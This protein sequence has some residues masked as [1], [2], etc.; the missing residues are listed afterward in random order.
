MKLTTDNLGAQLMALAKKGYDIRPVFDTLGGGMDMVT[1]ITDDDGDAY[2]PECGCK[3]PKLD[4]PATACEKLAM[5]LAATRQHYGLPPVS[6]GRD[7]NRGVAAAYGP[8]SNF[9]G[10]LL[11]SDQGVVSDTAAAGTVVDVAFSGSMLSRLY[12]CQ[13]L[14][15]W[16][17]VSPQS[18]NGGQLVVQSMDVE[19]SLTINDDSVGQF[20]RVVL[21]QIS[22]Q[23][24]GDR[25]AIDLR[26]MNV[27]VPAG[28]TVSFQVR[29]IDT[30]TGTAGQTSA[31]R[32]MVDAGRPGGMRHKYRK[33]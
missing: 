30:L 19:V 8:G 12:G 1:I 13:M 21:G 15:V 32:F 2:V 22:A 20:Q 28:A 6:Y 9:I 31:V 29:I 4:D 33:I 18:Q 11:R 23:P 24:N 17:T 26:E 27:W 7:E 25:Q 10:G 3:V 5:L 16:A 14:D